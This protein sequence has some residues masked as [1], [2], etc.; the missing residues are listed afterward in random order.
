M[1]EEIISQPVVGATLSP[2]SII[3]DDR[4]K[5]KRLEA[6]LFATGRFCEVD[7][8]IKY[9]SVKDRRELKKLLHTLQDEY[10]KREGAVKIIEV[11]NEFKMVVK[12]EYLEDIRKALSN[13]EISKAVLE[14]LAVI[15]WKKS[16][17]QSDVIKV[18][19]NAAYEHIKELE[20]TNF[21]TS[22]KEGLSKKLTLTE[23]FYEYFNL[24]GE[25][26]TNKMRREEQER[27]RILEEEIKKKDEEERKLKEEDKLKKIADRRGEIEKKK[28]ALGI[29]DGQKKVNESVA[30]KIIANYESGNVHHNHVNQVAHVSVEVK[31]EEHAIVTKKEEQTSEIKK[32]EH[33]TEKKEHH[34]TE[35]EVKQ[36]NQ[37]TQSQSEQK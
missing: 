23:K 37:H 35:H 36:D 11:D 33:N 27:L 34:K 18:R 6:I 19:G 30:D 8:L 7:E 28:I 14:T 32:E 20:D 21:V 5:I 12:D 10:N 26:L 4:N 13:M 17:I 9:V 24:G 29:V 15:A 16:I 2:I 1:S 25:D 3:D 22:V 31:K